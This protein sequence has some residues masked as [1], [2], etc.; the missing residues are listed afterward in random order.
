M[1]L[2]QPVILPSNLSREKEPGVAKHKALK[3][4]VPHQALSSTL[5]GHQLL[6][7]HDHAT[8]GLVDH[9]CSSGHTLPLIHLESE[10]REHCN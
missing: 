2:L 8:V 4:P 1:P 7:S 9:L 3:A 10:T 6:W 5:Q